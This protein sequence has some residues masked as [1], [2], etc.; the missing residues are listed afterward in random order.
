MRQ[1][2]VCKIMSIGRETVTNDNKQGGTAILMNNRPLQFVK[3]AGD[4]LLPDMRKEIIKWKKS[5]NL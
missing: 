5:K 2:I 4:F 3:I 1:V